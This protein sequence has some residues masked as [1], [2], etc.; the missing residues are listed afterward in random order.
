MAPERFKIYYTPND[1]YGGNYEACSAITFATAEAAV[2]VRDAFEKEIPEWR[3][4]VREI[5]R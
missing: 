2:A 5:E 4:F 3:W 1:K